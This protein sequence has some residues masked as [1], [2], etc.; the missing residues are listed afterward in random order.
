MTSVLTRWPWLK[1]VL[2]LVLAACL[3]PTWNRIHAWTTANSLAPGHPMTFYDFRI[4]RSQVIRLQQTG[5]LYETETPGFYK[6]GS[7]V[8]KF[9]PTYAAML[10]SLSKL[11]R[12]HAMRV[13]LCFNF[14]ILAATLV[15]LLLNLRPKPLC[16]GVIALTFIN[17]QPTW[18]S[19]TGLQVE[20][21]ILLMLAL[22]FL[23]LS[24]GR[25]FLAGMPI[26]VAA[27]LKVYPA[28]LVIYFLLRRQGRVVLGALAGGIVA[29]A[30]TMIALDPKYWV[31]Y[32][33]WVFPHL[34]GTSL[35]YGNLG[36]LGALGRLAILLL[37]GPVALQAGTF[38]IRLLLTET[39]VPHALPLA[40]GLFA[41]VALALVLTSILVFRR[42]PASSAQRRDSL[43]LMFSICLLIFFMPTSWPDYQTTL[44][45]PLIAILMLTPD[46]PR[47]IAA[48]ALVVP[49]LLAGVF[50]DANGR[51][52]NQHEVFGSSARMLIPL[53]LWAA[54]LTTLPRLRRPG[55]ELERDPSQTD[56]LAGPERA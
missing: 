29:V 8:Y 23:L 16:A 3:I 44:I 43:G 51:F 53:L 11:S 40:Q 48:W 21:L 33:L 49:A 26:G 2:W 9:P 15:M 5:I 24:S 54:T 45:L 22:S 46:L 19:L 17:W 31:E 1:I 37:A 6:P 50:L 56:P 7:P 27:A 18:E 42:A 12:E 36:A 35:S 28:A 47:P 34:G 52:Y 32:G 4:F 20:P 38:D 13:A 30:L 41:F 10:T 55:G 25:L 14:A 39:Q